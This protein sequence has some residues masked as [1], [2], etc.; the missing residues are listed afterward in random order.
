MAEV[1]LGVR[2]RGEGDQLVQAG[3]EELLLLGGQPEG[4]ESEQ[5]QSVSTNQL[6]AEEPVNK[7]T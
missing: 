7:D 4:G 3:G 6:G 2:L 1:D 5:L